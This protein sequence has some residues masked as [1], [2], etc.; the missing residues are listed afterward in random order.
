METH[1]HCD[2]S[3]YCYLPWTVVKPELLT[4]EEVT[5]VALYIPRPIDRRLLAQS[6][7]FTVHPSPNQDLQPEE[8]AEEAKLLAPNSLNLVEFKVLAGMKPILL[9]QLEDLGISRK[10]LFPDLEGLSSHV[11]WGTTRTVQAERNL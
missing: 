2:G 5:Q 9:K 6:G 10:L 1:H 8:P 4:P 7:Q 3:I 11:N